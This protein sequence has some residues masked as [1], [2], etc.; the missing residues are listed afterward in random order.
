MTMRDLIYG[1]DSGECGLP[2]GQSATLTANPQNRHRLVALGAPCVSNGDF[3]I[4]DICVGVQSLLE[5]NYK[6]GRKAVFRWDEP[7]SGEELLATTGWLY[8]WK[9]T[10][11][12]VGNEVSIIVKNVSP[13]SKRFVASVFGRELPSIAE[14]EQRIEALEKIVREKVL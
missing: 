6:G 11:V 14:L 13:E 10:S 8:F 1:F 9:K 12:E 2:P 3:E 5:W 7:P 4:V